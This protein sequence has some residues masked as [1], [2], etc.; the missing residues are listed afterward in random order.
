M[1]VISVFLQY[2]NG[3]PLPVTLGRLN[4]I[5]HGDNLISNAHVAAPG[6]KLNARLSFPV[7]YLPV[8]SLSS[9][10]FGEEMNTKSSVFFLQ[11]LLYY[12]R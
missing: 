8:C 5:Q 9:R 2:L 10:K 4:F 1:G 12:S 3:K 11:P 7:R 6:G